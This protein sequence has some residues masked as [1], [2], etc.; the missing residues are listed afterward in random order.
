[1]PKTAELTDPIDFDNIC[2]IIYALS[3]IGQIW[4][5]PPRV[6]YALTPRGGTLIPLL[7]DFD[8]WGQQQI[9]ID[10]SAAA[11]TEN[12]MQD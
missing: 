1:M 3:F 8:A 9:E 2:P 12:A 7:K 5:I 10:R 6:E 11:Q 4:K